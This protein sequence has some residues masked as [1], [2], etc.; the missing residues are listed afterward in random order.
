MGG[1]TGCARARARACVYL[2][3]IAMALNTPDP[4]AS[5][6]VR[7]GRRPVSMAARLAE[8]QCHALYHEVKTMPS[9]AKRA[10]LGVITLPL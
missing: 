3:P 7:G 6:P 10:R 4:E 8:Q 1:G 5:T 2:P 9:S